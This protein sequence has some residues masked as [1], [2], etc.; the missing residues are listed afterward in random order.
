M[1]ALEV[2]CFSFDDLNY[3]VDPFEFDGVHGVDWDGQP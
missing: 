2:V 1:Q 3:V